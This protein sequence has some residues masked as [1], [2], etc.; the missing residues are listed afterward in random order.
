MSLNPLSSSFRPCR[1]PALAGTAILMAALTACGGGSDTSTTPV[2]VPDTTP[3]SLDLDGTAAVGRALAGATVNA[4]C[5]TGTGTA[6]AG[7][8]GS[9]SLRITGG[10]LPCVL[11]AVSG[12]TTLHS[13]AQGTGRSATANITPL[14][15]MVVAQANGGDAA[16]LFSSFD[17]TAQAK[18]SSTALATATTSVQTALA[19]VVDIAGVNPFTD[20]L[21]AATGSSTGN[22][23]D[24]KL[25]ALGTKLGAA[26][27]TLAQL[28]SAIARSGASAATVVASQVQ[29]AASHCASLRS[30][31]YVILNP[32]EDA[33]RWVQQVTIDAATLTARTAGVNGAADVV[34][35]PAVPVADKP[36]HFRT[37]NGQ[38]DFV[39]STSGVIVNRY[40]AQDGSNVARLAV[41]MPKQTIAAAELAGTWNT[42]EF[43]PADGGALVNSYAVVTIDNT[44]STISVVD[45]KYL[46]PC[47]GTSSV[48]IAA[49]A[50]GGF[51]VTV[52]DGSVMRLFAYKAANGNLMF[53]GIGADGNVV[54]GTRQ[55]ALTLPASGEQQSYWDVSVNAQGVTGNLTADVR[56]FT[57][58]DAA[59]GSYTR[60]ASF[61][62]TI[63]S[64]TINSPRPGMRHR[65]T[66]INSSGA[67]VSC[68]MIA[69]PLTG[70]GMTVYGDADETSNYFGISVARPAGSTSTGVQSGGGTASAGNTGTA[71]VG[72][73]V[74]TGGETYPLR[75]SMTISS[76]GQI[77][78]GQY[79]FHKLDGT[80]TACEHSAANDATCH[81]TSAFF[82]VTSQGGPMTTAGSASSIRL[83]AGPDIY[84]YTY[85]GT[86]SG[87]RWTGTWTK[88]ATGNSTL[89]GSGSFAVDLVITQP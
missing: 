76:A 2:P 27:L 85:T 77:T 33:A 74:V 53:A 71:A 88:V 31:P 87:V 84:G 3:T 78:G 47:G 60:S 8:D 66:C 46:R 62:G 43:G 28:I 4:K 19:S 13:V 9:F 12:T 41:G 54:V 32:A 49:N 26:K 22:A 29:P 48:R 20:R 80:M 68:G 10:V 69:L 14:T 7:T 16:A 75:A 39:V 70:M 42:V 45:C 6:T 1:V 65:A 82:S 23:L 24:V 67:T 89:T 64:F 30:G 50:A 57:A 36:C 51:D 40:L 81:G 37:S 44:G 59:A 17:T 15:E 83:V 86:L 79:D 35:A 63:D 73:L 58:V 52:A 34:S 55:T 72:T 5:A 18:V 25:D 56:T 11:Q 61:G 21:V 38:E